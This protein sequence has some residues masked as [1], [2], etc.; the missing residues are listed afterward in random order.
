MNAEKYS[1]EFRFSTALEE[2]KVLLLSMIDDP[3]K[4]LKA[5]N[6]EADDKVLRILDGIAAD[7]RKRAVELFK[8]AGVEEACQHCQCCGM[9]GM[10]R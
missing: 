5:Y 6:M 2:D 8:Q 9:A 1:R 7:V 10:V 3:V 4:T